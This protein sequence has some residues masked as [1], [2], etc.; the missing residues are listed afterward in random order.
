MIREAREEIG[1][2]VQSVQL[3]VVH[4]MHRK[5]NR[6]NM[7]VFFEC[8]S[9]AGDVVNRE[10]NK[11]ERL[12]FFSSDAL[13]PNTVDYNVAALKAIIEGSFY[14]ECGWQQ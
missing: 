14:S 6:L 9:W 5:T 11:C 1:I 4:V 10:P 7:D 8:V 13:P 12:A 2:Q 3:K